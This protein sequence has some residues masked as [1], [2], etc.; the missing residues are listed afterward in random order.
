[1]NNGIPWSDAER[2][3]IGPSPIL[4]LTTQPPHGKP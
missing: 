1:M 3:R 4:I 2:H